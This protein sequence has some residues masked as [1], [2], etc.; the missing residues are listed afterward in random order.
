MASH[1]RVTE[2]ALL[3]RKIET[4][5]FEKKVSPGQVVN[6][7]ISELDILLQNLH[8]TN[9]DCKDKR[10]KQY[11]QRHQQNI[12]YDNFLT[13]IQSNQVPIIMNTSMM[14]NKK[15]NYH[16]LVKRL[17]HKFYLSNI[18]VQ[19]TDKSKVFHLGKLQDYHKKS[20]EYM[21]KT[22]AY[23]C[24]GANDPS[25][26]LIDRTNKY[27]LDLRLAHW[28]TQ[29]QYEELSIKPNEV[30]LAHLYYLPK[31]HKSGTPL[32]PIVSGLQTP[33]Y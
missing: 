19:K 31:A 32:R 4:R 3:K 30:K 8:N 29:K 33:D 10:H 6:K 2:L 5:F 15:T 9:I 20:S 24:L 28:I 22:A 12:S 13:M 27:L 18:I 7:F 1:R 25:A 17:K 26:D 11:E 21:N 14:S 23:T 16:R